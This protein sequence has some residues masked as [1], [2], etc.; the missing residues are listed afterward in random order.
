MWRM[1]VF[2]ATAGPVCARHGRQFNYN[3]GRIPPR[4]HLDARYKDIQ[5]GIVK[6]RLGGL[7]YSR[8]CKTDP[9]LYRTLV[10]LDTSTAGDWTGEAY[11]FLFLRLS[12]QLSGSALDKF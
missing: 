8:R 3:T 2:K 4:I 11:L 12:K 9:G 10:R 1:M 5:L 6:L 7:Q